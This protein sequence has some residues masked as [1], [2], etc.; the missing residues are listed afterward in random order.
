MAHTKDIQDLFKYWNSIVFSHCSDAVTDVKEADG[1]NE[2][3][4]D[5]EEMEE[6][7]NKLQ[8]G[9]EHLPELMLG[10]ALDELMVSE[11]ENT[12]AGAQSS[13]AL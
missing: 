11:D 12:A 3:D 7:M 10:D 8:L 5:G 13:Q 2:L 6:L 1:G 9:R 4:G